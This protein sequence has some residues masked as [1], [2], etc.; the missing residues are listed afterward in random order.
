MTLQTT[1]RGLVYE[2]SGSFTFTGNVGATPAHFRALSVE[3]SAGPVTISLIEATIV[4]VIGTTTPAIAK[5][6]LIDK[7][8]EMLIHSNSTI[9]DGTVL[10]TRTILAVGGG[11]HTSG[12]DNSFTGE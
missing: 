12:G 5:N 1:H 2:V 3:S 9:T 4:T 7:P 6:R 10:G 11:A 8:A